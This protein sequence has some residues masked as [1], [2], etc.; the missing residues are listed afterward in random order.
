M[1][2]WAIPARD[3][4]T[5]PANLARQLFAAIRFRAPASPAD[6]PALVV[7]SAGDRLV[8][9]ECSIAIARRWRAPLLLHPR[10]GHEIALDDPA[11]LARQCARWAAGLRRPGC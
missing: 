11:W 8:S 6:T 2:L 4:Q 5:S 3:A 10:A 7:A 1:A 9:V